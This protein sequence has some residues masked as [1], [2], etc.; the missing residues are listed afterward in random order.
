MKYLKGY[1]GFMENSQPAIAPSKPTTEP[2]V[3]PGKPGTSPSRPSPIRRDKPSV[4]PAPKA[5]VEDV[6]E[7]FISLAKSKNIDFKKELD[8]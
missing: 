3:R 2:D 1:K 5:T 8:K 6:V 7:K 4:E